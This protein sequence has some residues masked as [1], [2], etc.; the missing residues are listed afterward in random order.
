MP[1]R[2]LVVGEALVDVTRRADGSVAEHPGGSPMNVAVAM[3][4]LGVDTT[5]ASQLGEDRFGALVRAHLSASGVT[6]VD[7]G[8]PGPTASATATLDADGA[9]SY[10][11]DIDWDPAELPDPSDFDLVHVG[12]IG[13]WMAPGSAVVADLARDAAG[14][15]QAV[16]FD[17]N[18]RLSL[19]PG[20]DALRQQ[21]LDIAGHSRFLKLSDEDAAVL[22]AVGADP[23]DVLLELADEGPALL[24]LTRGRQAT[25]LR[26]AERRVEVV[27]PRVTVV[28]TIG[29]GDSWM[30]ALLTAL[31]ERDW[32]DRESFPADDLRVVGEFAAAAAAITCSRA[33]ADPPWRG[34]SLNA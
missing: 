3:S 21:V 16:S 33:G 27:A 8:P 26:S 4:R 31:L 28:D 12:S 14:R 5:L 23:E 34:K 15:G 17:P 24:A 19:S 10:E 2:A 18:V 32:A 1:P 29:A 7:T 13:A 9:A 11:F 22:G 6:L 30:G 20:H 25:V